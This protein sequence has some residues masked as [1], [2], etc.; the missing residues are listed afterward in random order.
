LPTQTVNGITQPGVG[1][2]IQLTVLKTRLFAGPSESRPGIPYD[3]N[4]T[5]F[6]T[7]IQNA[8]N[9]T[10]GQNVFAVTVPNATTI[11]ITAG[12]ANPDPT[13]TNDDFYP[14]SNAGQNV[15]GRIFG[16]SNLPLFNAVTPLSEFQTITFPANFV[17]T[18]TYTV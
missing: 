6:Q 18:S 4:T 5:N 1:D 7:S 17:A 16:T 13:G 3:T 2:L 12:T 10:F 8:L 15:S 11:N 9:Y 14:P